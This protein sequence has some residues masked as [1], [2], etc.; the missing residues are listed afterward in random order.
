M[1]SDQFKRMGR[2]PGMKTY[3]YNEVHQRQLGSI[4]WAH[5]GKKLAKEQWR[6]QVHAYVDEIE[7]DW[8]EENDVA[9]VLEHTNQPGLVHKLRDEIVRL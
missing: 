4:P 9:A 6:K 3:I 1:S 7:P 5:L 2:L 8:Q